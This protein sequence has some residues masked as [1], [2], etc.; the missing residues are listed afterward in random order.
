MRRAH[1]IRG[2]V[3]VEVESD[4][5]RRFAVGSR[6]LLS[7]KTGPTVEVE[8]VQSRRHKGGRIVRFEGYEERDHAELLGGAILEVDIGEVASAP[9]GTYYFF[10]LLGC[11]CRDRESGD[12]GKVLSVV[13]DGGGL[14]L[15]VGDEKRRLPVPFVERFIEQIDTKAGFIEFQLPAGLVEACASAS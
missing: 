14:L 2:E 1:G 3:Q 10:E 4:N 7:S 13:E 8:I 11:R 9:K 5:P 6:L 15:I 12:L